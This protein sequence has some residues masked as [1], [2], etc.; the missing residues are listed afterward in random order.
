MHE[1]NYYAVIY[2]II[3]FICPYSSSYSIHNIIHVQ[4][5]ALVSDQ[6]IYNEYYIM[7]MYAQ[8]QES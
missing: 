1:L 8:Q 2:I 7:H 4:Y 6:H 3:R 5:Y